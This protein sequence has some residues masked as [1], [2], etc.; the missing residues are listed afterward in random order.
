MKSE[1]P[2]A[3]PEIPVKNINEAAAYYQE[4]LGFT[5]DWSGEGVGLAGISQGNC[6]MF[7]ANREYRMGCG[8]VGPTVTWLNLESQE[9]VDELYGLWNVGKAKLTSTPELKPWGLYEFTAADLDGNLFRVFYDVATPE[10]A[11]Q[12]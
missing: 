2:G 7:L 4:K 12:S 6:R 11:K 9:D 1:F 3:V 10:R 8:N 5:L